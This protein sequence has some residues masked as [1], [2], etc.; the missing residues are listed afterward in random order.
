[1]QH[2][3]ETPAAQSSCAIIDNQFLIDTLQ[4]L[5]GASKALPCKYLYDERGSKLFDRICELDEY[6][7]TRTETQIAV[8]NSEVI[9]D[10]IGSQV[11]L[12]EYGSGSSVKTRVLLDHLDN[13]RA[14]LPVDI[15]EEHLL[16]TAKTLQKDYPQLDV[17]PIAA[18]FT[19]GFDLPAD[20]AK[21][22]TCVYF[23]GSTI[24]NLEPDAAKQVLSHIVEHSGSDG[25]LLIGFDLQKP[26]EVLELAYDDPHG[27]TAEFSLNLLER[28]NRE[29]DG[30]FDI[31][32]FEHVSFYN[33]S[34]GRIEI[35]IE[36]RVDQVV[37]VADEQF[38]FA[39][40]ERIHIEYSHKYTIEGFSEM[41]AAAGLQEQAYWTDPQQYFAMM[42]LSV[43]N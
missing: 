10:H 38:D 16:Q 19:E 29:L 11:V 22:R 37:T 7:P 23:P 21:E 20:L 33:R 27:V 39:E 31:A 43:L 5:S 34:R 36:S 26:V 8:D 1:M 42:Y 24:G 9:A 40:G 28:I 12:V 35:Y 2:F 30:D 3:S 15:S 13:P 41:A 17:R 32:Q 4:G 6:Y 14:Y 18:D 25:G